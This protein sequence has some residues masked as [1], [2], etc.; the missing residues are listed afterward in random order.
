MSQILSCD[1]L[2]FGMG[3]I[4]GP[5]G[6]EMRERGL[7]VIFVEKLPNTLNRKVGKPF[8]LFLNK[9]GVRGNADIWGQLSGI[10]SSSEWESIN[11]S[12]NLNIPYTTLL[13][14]YSDASKHGYPHPNL[15]N[16]VSVKQRK[17]IKTNIR[18]HYSDILTKE[19]IVV[20]SD[21]VSIKKIDKLLWETEFKSG[22]KVKSKAIVFSCGGIQNIEIIRKHFPEKCSER[23]LNISLHLKYFLDKKNFPFNLEID[24]RKSYGWEKDRYGNKYII[25]YIINNDCSVQLH[26]CWNGDSF[27]SVWARNIIQF[28]SI[29]W[30]ISYAY[31]NI[32]NLTKN[33]QA[34]LIGVN[35]LISF[36]TLFKGKLLRKLFTKYRAKSYVYQIHETI[37][38]KLQFNRKDEINNIK[39][40]IKKL[41]N[42]CSSKKIHR[43]YIKPKMLED[44]NHFCGTVF[45]NINYEKS[46]LI[47]GIVDRNGIFS[48]GTGNLP[49][50]LS[51][52]PTFTGMAL[53]FLTISEIEKHVKGS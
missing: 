6:F 42:Q 24:D 15:F 29:G 26:S 22:I 31:K 46:D 28:V 48:V 18:N 27:Y 8:S 2:Q 51:I 47:R 35:L 50:A 32:K 44:A 1:V 34:R 23:E 14:L 3:V 13:K 30:L 7:D 25:A 17:L 4:G 9:L 38:G 12:Y 45:Q 20:I 52:S 37:I 11:K 10:V 16:D 36:V 21:V 49:S 33:T 5:V 39:L 43:G 53:A 40:S 41:G 19:S